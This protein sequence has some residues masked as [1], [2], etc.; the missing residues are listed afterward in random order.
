MIRVTSNAKSV[1][2]R[3]KSKTSNRVLQVKGSLQRLY[4]SLSKDRSSQ[5]GKGSTTLHKRDSNKVQ[6]PETEG[7]HNDSQIRPITRAR[8]SLTGARNG[9][10][11]YKLRMPVID[12]ET[13]A[14][15][16]TSPTTATEK[17]FSQKTAGVFPPL[18]KNVS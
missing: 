4:S 16:M 12:S 14:I 15:T 11:T 9:N 10:A 13:Q 6:K 2:I 3:P 18:E 1:S 5:Q 17:S 8:Q 7:P